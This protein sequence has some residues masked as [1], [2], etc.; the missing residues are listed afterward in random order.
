[1]EIFKNPSRPRDLEL[2][3]WSPVG[4]IAFLNDLIVARPLIA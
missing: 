4:I 3:L 2:A 1:M